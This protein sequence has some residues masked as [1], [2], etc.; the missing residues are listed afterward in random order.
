MSWSKR[1]DPS[2]CEERPANCFEAP[3]AECGAW[4]TAQRWNRRFCSSTCRAAEWYRLHFPAR[5]IKRASA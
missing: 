4:F 2:R 5:H 1:W 3:C